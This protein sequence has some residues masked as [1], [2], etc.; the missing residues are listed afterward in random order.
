MTKKELNKIKFMMKKHSKPLSVVV[1]E[2]YL[3]DEEKMF[4]VQHLKQ[5][6]YAYD[7]QDLNY[8][9]KSLKSTT[10]YLPFNSNQYKICLLSDTHIGSI[11]DRMDAIEY[12]YE[13][14]DKRNVD[15][16]LHSG[17]FFEGILSVPNHSKE[18]I[19]KTVEE[20]IEF[21]KDYYP[22]SNKKTYVIDGNHEDVTNKKYKI[23][24]LDELQKLRS[25]LVFFQGLQANLQVGNLRILMEHGTAHNLEGKITIMKRMLDKYAIGAEPHI[26]QTGH[27]HQSFY[28]HYNKTHIFQTPSLMKN[29]NAHAKNYKPAANGVWWL[30]IELNKKG[31]VVYLNQELEIMGPNLIKRM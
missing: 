22:K 3:N 5:E 20:Q 16:Y 2:L 26:I 1:S 11:Y 4:V 28:F 8:K 23:N 7:E 14:G 21:A 31:E 30:D 17:D 15:F 9:N 18:L 10:F 27:I 19:C 12:V 13:K 29:R 24:L 6:G 25:D